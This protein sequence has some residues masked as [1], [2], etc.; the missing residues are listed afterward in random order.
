MRRLQP[1]MKSLNSDDYNAVKSALILQFSK[2]MAAMDLD[3]YPDLAE[4]DKAKQLILQYIAIKSNFEKAGKNKEPTG[5]LQVT[6]EDINVTGIRTRDVVKD[7]AGNPAYITILHSLALKK[8]LPLNYCD[9]PKDKLEFLINNGYIVQV[10]L[11]EG[12]N[13]EIL[14]Y[15]LSSKGWLCFIRKGIIDQLNKR[16]G[17]K[18]LYVPADLC[19]SVI[20]WDNED[21]LK[22]LI[23]N[24]YYHYI[25]AQNEYLIFSFPENRDLLIGCIPDETESIEYVFPVLNRQLLSNELIHTI[26]IIANTESICKL[27]LLLPSLEVKQAVEKVLANR[28]SVERKVAYYIMENK[29][30]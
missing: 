19:N 30:E 14:C 24:K 22:A 4:C 10:C 12:K 7:I 9:Y 18:M 5:S 3:K 16:L 11:K 29:D 26:E 1:V 21:Y 13:H 20:D 15:S 27:T 17:S 25:Q 23:L 28:K 2:L 8:I 6:Y